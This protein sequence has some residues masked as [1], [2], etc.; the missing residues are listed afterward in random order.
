MRQ[1]GFAIIGMTILF[2]FVPILALIESPRSF[3]GENLM[4]Y[5]VCLVAPL[6]TGLVLVL[7][8]GRR[9]HRRQ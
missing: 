9:D 8:G 7:M 6:I 4:F 1:W 3:F 5:L 2:M